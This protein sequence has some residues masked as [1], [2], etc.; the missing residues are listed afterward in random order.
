MLIIFQCPRPTSPLG[1]SGP[2]LEQESRRLLASWTEGCAS[3]L[4]RALRLSLLEF[5]VELHNTSEH[6]L[7]RGWRPALA[8]STFLMSRLEL[9][10]SDSWAPV[11]PDSYLRSSFAA[12]HF[13]GKPLLAGGSRPGEPSNDTSILRLSRN[14]IFGGA[15]W[16][17]FRMLLVHRLDS[18]SLAHHRQHSNGTNARV[19]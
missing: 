15:L 14:S 8:E 2:T 19:A 16:A 4:A 17:A 13:V 7:A 11:S 12:I 18:R 10:A 6:N 5:Q 3:W 9:G 1:S